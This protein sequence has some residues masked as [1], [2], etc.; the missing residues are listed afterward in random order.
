MLTMGVA[1][2]LKFSEGSK[3]RPWVIPIGLGFH[4]KARSYT[5]S[6]TGLS[7]CSMALAFSIRSEKQ[8]M[9]KNSS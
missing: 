7:A 9:M 5:R 4:V 6:N 2:N 3:I 1:P 8:S